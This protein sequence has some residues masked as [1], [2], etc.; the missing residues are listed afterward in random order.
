MSA[1]GRGNSARG[2]LLIAAGYAMW[3]AVGAILEVPF[4]DALLDRYVAVARER[5]G[6]EGDAVWAEGHAMSFDDAVTLAL[7]SASA[8]P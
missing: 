5:L 8:A 7:G 1:A 2:L 6:S 3:E 4:W